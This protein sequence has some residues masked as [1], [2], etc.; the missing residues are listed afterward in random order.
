MMTSNCF[1]YGV[2]SPKGYYSL[3]SRP[4]FSAGRNFVVK[5][6]R[7]SVKQKFFDVI[8]A[9]LDKRGHSYIDFRAD[10]KSDG[11]FSKDADLRV[12][13]GTYCTFDETDFPVIC[14]DDDEIAEAE[15]CLKVRDEAVQRTKRFLSACRC[16]SN[17][18]LRLEA[19]NIDLAKINRFSSR[20]WSSTGG[21]LTG[22]VGTEHKRFVTCF[23]SDGVELNMEAFDIYCDNVTVLCDKTGACAGR[24]VDRVR[25]YALSAGYDVISCLCPLNVDSGAE[26]IIIPELKYG[27]FVNKHFHKAD[28]HNCRK[29]FTGRFMTVGGA[30]N[31]NRMDF[32]F[33]AYKRLMQEVFSSLETVEFCDSELDK[34]ANKNNDNEKIGKTLQKVFSP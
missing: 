19:A 1:Y 7:P 8:K 12:I 15:P 27:I 18:M 10:G 14:L 21:S 3:A 33:K 17:D 2:Y 4:T 34:I 6:Y 22:A 31:K 16:I 28:F 5:G 11:V 13:D 24:I 30:E 20:L 29:V 9:E 23:T 32:S 26:H 25:R